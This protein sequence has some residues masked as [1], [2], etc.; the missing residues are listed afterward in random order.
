MSC[1]ER[2]LVDN[3]AEEGS[4]SPQ[5]A[6]RVEMFQNHAQ[7]KDKEKG[8]IPSLTLTLQESQDIVLPHGSLDV[9]DDRTASVVQESNSD[10]GDTTTGA[11]PAKDLTRVG[12]LVWASNVG[13]C[14]IC[15]DLGNSCELD[16]DFG[17]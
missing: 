6:R 9:T 14:E 16:G 10:L 7:H 2:E 11:S 4:I 15:I 3:R 1:S 12:E 13:L 8:H 17:C 5:T